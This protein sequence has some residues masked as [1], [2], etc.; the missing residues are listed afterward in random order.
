MTTPDGSHLTP[1]PADYYRR[2][3]EVELQHWWHQ[4]MLGIEAMLIRDRLRGS[5]LS[6]LDAGCGTGGFLAW[7]SGTGAFERLSGF[8]VS[9][10][11]VALAQAR[12]P[13]AAIVVG[14]ASSIA[15]P[16]AS[17]D[18]LTCNDVLQHIH[19]DELAGSVRELA[20]V[21]RPGGTVLVRTNGARRA[22]SPLPDWRSFD[23]VLLRG[24]L[25]TSGL[26]IDRLT[27]VNMALSAWAALRGRAP[28]P[29]GEHTHGIPR[30][31]GAL[32]SAIGSALMRG[33]RRYLRPQGRALPYGHTLIAVATR[34]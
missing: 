8:D 25:E 32:P 30:V 3:H 21:V 17:F 33:E 14:S 4:G 23:A 7:A 22:S 28:R 13:A 24:V 12:V 9:A 34:V 16:D 10:E 18:V 26:R 2:I 5:G 15:Q 31:P 1:L 20:R 29:P 6:L 19:D 11:A 27:H